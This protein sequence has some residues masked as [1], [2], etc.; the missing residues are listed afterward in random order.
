MLGN[1]EKDLKYN[2][3]IKLD[4]NTTLKSIREDSSILSTN[5]NNVIFCEDYHNLLAS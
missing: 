1:F 4:I 3:L 2:K 5:L